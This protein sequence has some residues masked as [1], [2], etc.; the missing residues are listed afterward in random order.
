MSTTEKNANPRGAGIG[1]M[2]SR[3]KR[4]TVKELREFHLETFGE[5]N[6][7]GNKDY[8]QKRIAW[9]LQS[10]TH[11]GLSERAQARALRLAQDTDIRTTAPKRQPAT[12]R[13]DDSSQLS[14]RVIDQRIPAPGSIITRVYKSRSIEVTVRRDG[15]EY[16]GELYR[17]LSAV[18]RAVTGAHQNGFAFFNLTKEG[19][20]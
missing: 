20:Q 8:L 13:S 16:D 18:A 6:P 7:S 2:I 4:M 15:F 5:T 3:L 14:P 1:H 19:W 10:K 9:R 12:N 11:G 17:S